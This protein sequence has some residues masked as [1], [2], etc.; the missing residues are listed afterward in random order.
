MLFYQQVLIMISFGIFKRA[1]SNGVLPT[2]GDRFYF[3]REAKSELAYCE[4]K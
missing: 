1:D 4:S 3:L 2:V